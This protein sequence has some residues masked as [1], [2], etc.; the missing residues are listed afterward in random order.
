[1]FCVLVVF[2][3]TL[4]TLH[5]KPNLALCFRSVKCKYQTCSW[6]GFTI[7]TDATSAEGRRWMAAAGSHAFYNSILSFVSCSS[8]N[9]AKLGK[10]MM[11]CCQVTLGE[12]SFCCVN[13]AS[14]CALRFSAALLR[15]PTAPTA[16]TGETDIMNVRFSNRG[17]RCK[18]PPHFSVWWPFFFPVV[19]VF[20]F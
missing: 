18:Q 2:P 7:S 17:C 8:I 11:K 19:F 3:N 10:T 5:S 1:M 12:M 13:H 9:L 15:S 4:A 6:L 20:P 14:G 16:S